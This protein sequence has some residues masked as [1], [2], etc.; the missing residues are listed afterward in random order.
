MEQVKN[1][2]SPVLEI[3]PSTTMLYCFS[4]TVKAST[5]CYLGTEKMGFVSHLLL[6]FVVAIIQRTSELGKSTASMW[7]P[8]FL[9]LGSLILCVRFS[10]L[11]RIVLVVQSHVF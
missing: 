7:T 10:E 6:A 4:M 2:G 5:A 8:A 11:Y 3:R 1:L 9:G